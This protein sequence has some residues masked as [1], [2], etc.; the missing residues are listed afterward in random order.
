MT[1]VQAHNIRER[2]QIDLVDLAVLQQQPVICD[3]RYVVSIL[4]VFSR[5]VWL[6]PIRDKKA[7]TVAEV[8]FRIFEEWGYPKIIQVDQGSEF[9]GHFEQLC[10]K[11]TIKLIRSSPGHPQSQGKI[12]RSH[13]SWKSKL[14][15][16][17]IS[18]VENGIKITDDI[19]FDYQNV[20]NTGFH[21]AIGMT[22]R[23][24]FFE[25]T[26][27]RV[28]LQSS[29][30]SA[31]AMVEKH[32][33]KHPCS[34]YAIGDL[35]LCKKKSADSRLVGRTGKALKLSVCKKGTILEVKGDNYLVRFGHNKEKWMPVEA[36]TS[37]TRQQEKEKAVSQKIISMVNLAT[38]NSLLAE[39][40]RKSVSSCGLADVA[41]MYGVEILDTPSDGNCQFSAIAQQ[42]QLQLNQHYS[43]FQV[44][45]A[46]VDFLRKNKIIL[47][48][49]GLVD[50]S[51][52]V[53]D[54]DVYLNQMEQEGEWGDHITLF[55]AP[56][57]F[58]TTITLL[59]D[60]LANVITIQPPPGTQSLANLLLG[61]VSEL[62]Y[63]GLINIQPA[64]LVEE[65][66]LCA[67]C[68]LLS[69]DNE[70][71]DCLDESLIVSMGKPHPVVPEDS[72]LC[73]FCG[74]I[75]I[76]DCDLGSQSDTSKCDIS[77]LDDATLAF[78]FALATFLVMRS[79]KTLLLCARAGMKSLQIRHF[80]IFSI[81]SG[82]K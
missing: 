23:E 32:A 58:Q 71:H 22:P 4:D 31:S 54:W 70:L 20:Y 14:R 51:Q 3:S 69:F 61:H 77:S 27:R 38:I 18:S 29:I 34:K 62:H 21:T 49:D 10:L 26:K 74:K 1:S 17:L 9:R 82:Q 40:N 24:C 25:Y 68:G 47:G 75:G 48:V 16:D 81:E 6:R 79:Q 7:L 2:Y 15:F 63:V 35:V 33:Q 37:V 19:F 11:H 60:S 44:R 28:A 76:H 8:V 57:V 78:I 41:E 73:C 59:S 30:S 52:F 39:Q 66:N 45:K 65:G 67:D 42:L 64:P 13:G 5:Y 46:I 53:D 50:L 80:N 56:A 36:I 12:E 43:A 55:A 72:F